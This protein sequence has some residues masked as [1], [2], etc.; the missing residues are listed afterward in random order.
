MGI[1][2]IGFGSR[3]LTGCP[4]Q[5]RI[6]DQA[7]RIFLAELERRGYPDEIKLFK[8]GAAKGADILMAQ[9]CKDMNIP[10]Q[11]FPAKWSDWRDLP[12]AKKRIVRKSDGREYNELAGHNRNREMAD[13]GFDVGLAIRMPGKSNG[14]DS[15]IEIIRSLGKSCMVYHVDRAHEWL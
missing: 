3:S 14:T 7:F 4:D 5:N 9:W 15:M 12:K 10:V 1:V 2:I 8:H 13:S 6:V 11:P